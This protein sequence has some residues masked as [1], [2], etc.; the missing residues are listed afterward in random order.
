MLGEPFIPPEFDN[1][2]S[3][4]K[5]FF[6]CAH[7]SLVI[8]IVGLCVTIFFVGYAMNNVKNNLE[9]MV[10]LMKAVHA[11]TRGMCFGMSVLSQSLG[12]PISNATCS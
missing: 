2:E 6:L 11:D 4:S 10:D 7:I 1:P 9:L 5:T 3:R 12:Q 8:S